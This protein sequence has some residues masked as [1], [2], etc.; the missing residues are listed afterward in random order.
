MWNFACN[1]VVLACFG[2]PVLD[3]AIK[4]PG[5][6]HVNRSLTPPQLAGEWRVDVH[7]VLA[8]IKS[9]E[10]RAA[11]LATRLSGRP[12]YRI[13]R[14]DA[15]AFW[16]RRMVVPLP[17]APKGVKTPAQVLQWLGVNL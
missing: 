6:S 1:V 5:V 10:L 14:E 7:R 3:S 9:G 16:H 11:N 13:S 12:R 8:W 17:K 2:P 4:G 15:E